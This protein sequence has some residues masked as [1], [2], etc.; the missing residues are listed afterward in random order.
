[1]ETASAWSASESTT[2]F[3]ALSLDLGACFEVTERFVRVLQ[4]HRSDAAEDSGAAS[5]STRAVTLLC[6]RQHYD[7][8]DQHQELHVASTTGST[9]AAITATRC[10]FS[11]IHGRVPWPAVQNAGRQCAA[12]IT[13]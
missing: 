7:L 6:R 4:P 9:A 5:I 13:T 1:M 3:A 10:S 12:A 8:G 2:V 11:P